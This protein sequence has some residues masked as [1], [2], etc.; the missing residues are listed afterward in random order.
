MGNAACRQLGVV[1]PGV[2]LREG[3]DERVLER[4]LAVLGVAHLELFDERGVGR[5][6]GLQHHV[7]APEAALAVG[8][9]AVAALQRHEE[10]EHQAVVEA[11]GLRL[12][13]MAATLPGYMRM[14]A[15]GE[16]DFCGALLE[17]T[18]AEVARKAESALSR[19]VRAAGFPYVKT[20][21]DF[22]FSFQPSVPKAAVEELATL[23]F[24]EDAENV[25]LVGS[26]GV[27]KTH[28]A[29][30]LGAEAVK[31][32]KEVRFVDC[33]KLVS[34]LR[35]AA[36]LGTLDKRIRYYAHASL[37]IVDELGC[38]AIDRDGAEMLFRLVSA[39][40]ERRS[41]IVTTNVGIP[42][43]RRCSATPSP[44]AR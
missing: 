8:A 27:G 16:R 5:S 44:R 22:D 29:V 40:Y 2:D 4:R 18:E 17:M 31:A 14:V 33:A 10:A 41:T 1:A 43:G 39:R 12:D 21:A 20:L 9:H 42:G 38:L 6:R 13:E 24:L 34:D 26:P 32:R 11:L 36:K 25:P 23:R 28:L 15:A 3:G 7:V 35:D 19:R 30:A 37:L